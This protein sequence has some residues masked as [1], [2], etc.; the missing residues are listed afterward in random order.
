MPCLA[1]WSP[2]AE[3]ILNLTSRFQHYSP[4]RNPCWFRNLAY[5][6]FSSSAARASAAARR[7]LGVM[8]ASACS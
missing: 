7:W 1:S 2:D 5:L 3:R 4:T 8:L 6:A